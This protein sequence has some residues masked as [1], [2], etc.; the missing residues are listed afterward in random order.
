MTLKEMLASNPAIAAEFEKQI[1]VAKAEGFEAGKKHAQARAD[2]ATPFLRADSTYGEAGR[3]LALQVLAGK[4]DAVA[5][6]A[7]ATVLDAQRE[8]TAQAQAQDETEAV[9]VTPAL[10]PQSVSED[11]ETT[12]RAS[13]DAE[14]IRRGLKPRYEVQ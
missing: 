6:Q 5:L 14:R 8:Q 3:N 11:S 4:I 13:V 7:V 2:A 12:F 10:P 1:E 9:P